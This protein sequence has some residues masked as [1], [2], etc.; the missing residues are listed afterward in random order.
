[1]RLNF[2]DALG[3]V[4][5]ISVEFDLTTTQGNVL[6]NLWNPATDQNVPITGFTSPSGSQAHTWA[7]PTGDSYNLLNPT[8][9]GHHQ[10]FFDLPTGVDPGS[11]YLIISAFGGGGT[12][13]P[14][15]ETLSGIF[16]NFLGTA[17]P[18]CCSLEP[19]DP[20]VTATF[21]VPCYSVPTASHRTITSVTN[22]D[23]V[24]ERGLKYQVVNADPGTPIQNMR[25]AVYDPTLI[26]LLPTALPTV[27][28][29]WPGGGVQEWEC[30][31]LVHELFVP[32]VPAGTT[33]EI[34]G[35]RRQN[36]R[37]ANGLP[38]EAV[39]GDRFVYGGPE[40]PYTFQSVPPCTT[41]AVVVFADDTNT[42]A[43]SLIDIGAAD[44][45]LVDG[46][47]A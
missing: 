38:A 21:Q 27:G 30:N 44:L 7:S 46:A 5:P 23:L 24:T 37:Y 13:N 26:G 9:I 28:G 31:A 45:H 12:G 10:I 2:G 35:C 6:I 15:D 41:Y 47:A 42:P 4:G 1:V 16:M 36:L 17:Q 20:I 8:S 39:S 22:P 29:V 34:D 19:G 40:R 33:I 43:G 32:E 11:L 14:I 18:A 3:G 25:I